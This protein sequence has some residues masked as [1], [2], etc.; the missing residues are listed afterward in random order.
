M[1]FK[2][3]LLPFLS[4]SCFVSVSLSLVGYSNESKTVSH[5]YNASITE[6]SVQ[7][8]FNDLFD[9]SGS[10]VFYS[11]SLNVSED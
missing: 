2:L 1:F 3:F 11:L 10:I 9:Y 7:Y 5:I 8:V 4:I 6:Q